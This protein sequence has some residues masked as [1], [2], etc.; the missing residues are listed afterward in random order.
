M[1]TMRNSVMLIGRPG[2]EPET[3][4]FD[5]NHII[6]RFRLAVNDSHTNANHERVN[7]TQWFTVVA[8]D[9]TAERIAQVV[10]KGKRIAVDGA[11]HNN[12]RTDQ[13]GVRHSG[14]EIHVNNF[15]LLDWGKELI[16]E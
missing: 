8:W 10:K 15:V 2:T 6:S 16:A 1:S 7:T 5:N 4:T 9:K 13:N 11:L 12:E 3:K 14:T